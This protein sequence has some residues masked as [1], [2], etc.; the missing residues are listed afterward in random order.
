MHPTESAETSMAR[1]VWCSLLPGIADTLFVLSS[2]LVLTYKM[3]LE[4]YYKLTT[5][6]NK[7]KE[8]AIRDTDT[9]IANEPQ[10]IPH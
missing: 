9:D 10:M 1:P 4:E 8:D 7:V 2:P 5:I 6:E 3:T